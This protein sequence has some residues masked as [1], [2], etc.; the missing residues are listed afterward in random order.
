MPAKL[1][2]SIAAA[3][4]GLMMAAAVADAHSSR[5][6]SSGC[7]HNRQTGGSHCH[8]SGNWATAKPRTAQTAPSTPAVAHG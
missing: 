6:N 1:V 8:N 4:A 5:T 7:H 3:Y 2:T